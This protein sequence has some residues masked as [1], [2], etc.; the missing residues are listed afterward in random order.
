VK[1]KGNELHFPSVGQGLQWNT[2]LILDWTNIDSRSREYSFLKELGVKE[3][4]DL[5]KLI[6]RIN[7]EHQ[8]QPKTIANYKLPKSFTFFVE[9]FRE[10]YSK[11][12]NNSNIQI[13]FLPSVF[14]S[15]SQSDNVILT[16]PQSVFKGFISL[17]LIKETF[18]V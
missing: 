5:K 15:T 16:L 2:L 4:P 17:F 6:L 13:P 12:W 1:Y 7:E 14:P 10:H 11:L 9:H 3:V 8:N 18:F